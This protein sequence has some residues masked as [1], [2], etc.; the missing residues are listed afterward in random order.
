MRRITGTKLGR[1]FAEEIAGPLGADFH[2]GLPASEDHRVSNVVPPPPL[3]IDMAGLDPDSVMVKTFSGP[4]PDASIAWTE[5]WRRADIGAANGHGNA[6]SVARIQ[7][8]VANGGHVGGVTL[9][10]PKTIDRIFEPQSDGVDLVLGMPVR[11]GIGYALPHSGSTPYLPEGRRV[12]FW[13]GW[14]G[15]LIVVDLDRRMTVAYMMNK[16][17]GGLVGN[18]TSEKLMTAIYEVV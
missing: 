11:F 15:S 3:P 1:F 13:G 6:R 12:C 2:I 9:L 10:S 7:A 17:A 18:P 16:M 8:V 14:G 4:A 5:A